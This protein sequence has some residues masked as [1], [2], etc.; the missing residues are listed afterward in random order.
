MSE[1][2]P[3]VGWGLVILPF[4]GRSSISSILVWYDRLMLKT[5]AL[6]R[7]AGFEAFVTNLSEASSFGIL[8]QALTQGWWDIAHTSHIAGS[9][10]TLTPYDFHRLTG[11]KSYS[12]VVHLG[13][14][15]GGDLVVELLG[16][17][18][19]N[20]TIQNY[21]LT[22]DFTSHSQATPKDRARMAKASLLRVVGAT[23]LAN[24]SQTVPLRWLEGARVISAEKKGASIAFAHLSQL[25][26][27]YDGRG[28]RAMVEG[29]DLFDHLLGKED[30]DPFSKGQLMPTFRAT[31][32]E[33]GA[34]PAARDPRDPMFPLYSV[35]AYGPNGIARERILV[36]NANW[37]AIP[38]PT[39]AECEEL[40]PM[41]TSEGL[42]AVAEA[43][44][45]MEMMGVLL[46][47]L[48]IP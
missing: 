3:W 1:A 29:T 36:R 10:M 15:F 33:A 9:E 8:V 43:T 26:G 17:A 46:L 4:I 38:L 30:Y 7:V 23:V 28:A 25:L 16:C 22:R 20:E 34:A 41:A 24:A 35:Y 2:D 27:E 45:K 47:R 32:V 39:H 13:D 5:R 11:L 40:I 18:H 6:V 14:A 42:V 12:P 19:P 37:V 21:L 31:L 44:T 48:H